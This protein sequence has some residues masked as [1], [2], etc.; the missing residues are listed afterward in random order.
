MNIVVLLSTDFY[1][2]LVACSDLNSPTTNKVE[3]TLFLAMGF[4]VFLVW[5]I[6]VA[7]L[8]RQALTLLFLG[9]LLYIVG[10]VFFILGNEY[11]PIYHVIWHIFVVAAAT[12]HWFAVY[13]FVLQ[14]SR[15]E[16]SP[17]KA[18][19]NDF[20]DSVEA[21]ANLM[22]RTFATIQQEL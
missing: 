14:V 22:N 1:S 6:L 17:T 10:I 4:G 20:V 7:E 16:N 19:V 3:L 12:I 18:A 2:F 8:S 9:G 15:I 11:K 21:A 5:D 13:F